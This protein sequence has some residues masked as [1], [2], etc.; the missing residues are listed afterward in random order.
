MAEE[1]KLGSFEGRED[2]STERGKVYKL[3]SRME[4][5]QLELELFDLVI[6]MPIVELNS[7]RLLHNFK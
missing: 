7:A 4:N 1:N 5:L 3:E 2:R 6:L